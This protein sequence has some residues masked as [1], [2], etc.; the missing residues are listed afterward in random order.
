MWIVHAGIPSD[1]IYSVGRVRV[2]GMQ[3]I[4][5]SV[6][7]SQAERIADRVESGRAENRSE[8]MRQ[9]LQAAKY[10]SNVRE[11]IDVAATAVGIAGL[12]LVGFTYFMDDSVRTL[13]LAPILGSSALYV[14][15]FL[16]DAPGFPGVIVHE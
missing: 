14:M 1:T 15:G 3:K 6:S 8:A 4:S 11:T 13:A 10:K 7:E 12:L 9:E 2:P 16:I 5:V